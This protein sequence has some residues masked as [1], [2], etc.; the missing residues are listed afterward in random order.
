VE[1]VFFEQRAISSATGSFLG[2]FKQC[3]AAF[4]PIRFKGTRRFTV[5]QPIVDK[6]SPSI[7][8]SGTAEPGF[9]LDIAFG[10]L[11]TIVA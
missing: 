7:H 3:G 9:A 11:D 4:L 2:P 8:L 5:I 1:T 10:S 6:L